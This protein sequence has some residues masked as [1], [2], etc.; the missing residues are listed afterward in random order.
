MFVLRCKFARA[1]KDNKGIAAVEFALILPVMLLLYIGTSEIT[2]ALM[3]NRKMTQV[4]RAVSD[5]IAQETS[6]DEKITN[7]T[8]TDIYSSAGTIMAPFSTT[9][10]KI[11]ASSIK[12]VPNAS[13]PTQ[14]KAM[15]VWSLT[16][17]ASAIKRPCGQNAIA[18]APNTQDAS[19]TTMPAGLYQA[20]T[21]IVADVEYQ[22]DPKF[23]G[24]LMKWGTD[25][26][27]AYNMKHTAYM[28]PRAMT[29]IH[30]SE[31]SPLTLMTI[32]N[33]APPSTWN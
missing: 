26:G 32:C 21:I 8:L 10:L 3:A 5:L 27:S 16:N 9:T 6:T 31:P 30:Y 18:S 24:A 17:K 25:G 19:P 15:T 11:T 1:R 28:K 22:Y 23:G 2:T 13:D 33:P 12:F 29:E 14:L 7:A 20:G 4:A